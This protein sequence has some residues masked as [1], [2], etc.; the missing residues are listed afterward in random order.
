MTTNL[1]PHIQMADITTSYADFAENDTDSVKN[2]EPWGSFKQ[3][4]T[5]SQSN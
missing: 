4:N 5:E 2:E 1:L 3:E